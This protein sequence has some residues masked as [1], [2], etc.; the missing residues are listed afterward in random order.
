MGDES[1]TTAVPSNPG[2][3]TTLDAILASGT[4]VVVRGFDRQEAILDHLRSAILDVVGALEGERVR[5]D[6]AEIGL[7][8]MHECVRPERLGAIRDHVMPTLRP[9][10]FDLT[11]RIARTILG[12]EG[13]F[14]VDDYTILRINYPYEVARTA[15]V[16]SENPGHGRVSEA[17]KAMSRGERVVDPI[18]D[19]RGFHGHEAPP[20]WAHGPHLD[21]WTGHSRDGVNLW[22]A[23]EDV[24]PEAS[25][26][27]Y[28]ESFRTPLASDP[29][30]LYLAAGF[31][32]PKPTKLALRKGEMVIFNPELL[33]GTHLNTSGT[34]RL[35]LSTRINPRAP[36]FSRDCFY[37]R[38]FWHSSES[39]ENG[40]YDQVVR[41]ERASHF[42]PTARERPRTAEPKSIDRIEVSGPLSSE[43]LS[44]CPS[45]RIARGAKL[46]VAVGDVKVV[47]VRTRAGLRAFEERCPHLDV[48]LV[49]GYHDD[50]SIY[51][52][53]HAV[54]FALDSGRSSCALLRLKTFDVEDRHGSVALRTVG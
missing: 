33:H 51:C 45:E 30:S 50:E 35:A 13:E 48:S 44:I 31:P 47:I 1:V 37:A 23:V 25:M 38:E 49:D 52:P 22:W 3:T 24:H 16:V 39:L 12:I 40:R 9:M 14:F 29:R 2:S 10:L 15:D 43:W 7:S 21:T 34:T 28:P 8:R 11:C 17:T 36:K 46:G 53:T 42:E 41:F 20:A 54:A 18:Y 27:F 19:P 6:L 32:L 4:Y 5:G 26:V